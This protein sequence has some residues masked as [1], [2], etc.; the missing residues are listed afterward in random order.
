MLLGLV[1]SEQFRFRLPSL[2]LA[3][4]IS[5]SFYFL[6]ERLLSV[7]PA[8]LYLNSWSGVLLWLILCRCFSQLF[9]HFY[10]L[11]TVLGTLRCSLVS[12]FSL[13]T[14][15]VCSMEGSKIFICAASTLCV[16]VLES[17]FHFHMWG[18]FL[19]WYCVVLIEIFWIFI[20]RNF[21]WLFHLFCYRFVFWILRSYY[22]RGQYSLP[23]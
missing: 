6:L 23:I 1:L 16:F 11:L 4:R 7:L 15:L 12:V 18:L 14:S 8:G 13:R 17:N 20:F 10:I 22:R 19:I 3:L 5:S 9:W 21:V 2:F